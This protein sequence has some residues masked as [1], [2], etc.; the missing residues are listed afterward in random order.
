M[1]A[2][3]HTC[4]ERMEMRTARPIVPYKAGQATSE[5]LTSKLVQYSPEVILTPPDSYERG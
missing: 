2:F 3:C 4:E 5:A 1:P